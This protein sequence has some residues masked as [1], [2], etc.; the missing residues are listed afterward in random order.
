MCAGDYTGA[1]R[2]LIAGFKDEA[3]IG[4]ADE[5]AGR[6][7]L[8]AAHLLATVG[9]PGSRYCLV[10]IPSL[11]AA[12]RER[13][14]DHTHV[15][16]RATA[17]RL[18]REVGLVVPVTRLLAARGRGPD[19]AGL[20]AA[21]R[22]ANRRNHF[23]V[24]A[25]PGLAATRGRLEGRVPILVDDVTTTG[26]TLASAALALTEAGAPPLGAIVVAATIKR[27]GARAQEALRS[28]PR[29]SS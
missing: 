1:V 7:A 18:R 2:R 20:D 11:P 14:L 25:P 27:Y 23:V 28:G 10:P 6:L 22:Q 17:R 15:L 9:R 19:Q 16:A 13:G 8:A 24:R 29:A 5:L 3:L 21:A 4:S 12:V 26:A